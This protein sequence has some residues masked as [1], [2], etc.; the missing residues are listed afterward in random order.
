MSLLGLLVATACSDAPSPRIGDHWQAS[1]AINICGH[2]EK[3]LPKFEGGV[4]TRGDG[5][6]H[7]QPALPSEEGEGA[8]LVEFFRNAGGDLSQQSLGLPGDRPWRTGNVCPDG[9]PGRVVVVVNQNPLGKDLDSYVPQDGDRILIA[10]VPA[11][12]PAPVLSP[13]PMPA[14]D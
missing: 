13:P 6:I 14:N 10:F 8:R 7:V 3:P 12:S 5:V 9:R 11:G 1:Y 4:Y 2:E